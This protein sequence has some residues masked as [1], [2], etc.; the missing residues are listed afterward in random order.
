L[1]ASA[2]FSQQDHDELLNLIKEA[3]GF[4]ASSSRRG[5]LRNEAVK[6][7]IHSAAGKPPPGLG[8]GRHAVLPA[9]LIEEQ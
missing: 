8:P 5:S 4:H 9:S 2:S 6:P 7:N 3:A 1:A